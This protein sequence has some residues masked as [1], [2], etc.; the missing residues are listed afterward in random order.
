MLFERLGNA[1]IGSVG[2][3][4]GTLL[5]MFLGGFLC[6]VIN[7]GW[8]S[9]WRYLSGLLLLLGMA[10]VSILWLIV[11]DRPTGFAPLRVDHLPP[12]SPPVTWSPDGRF[13]VFSGRDRAIPLWNVEAGKVERYLE[14]R[15]ERNSR[16]AFSPDG[17]KVLAGST[18]GI[19]RIWNVETGQQ[20]RRFTRGGGRQLAISPDGKLA[21]AGGKVD[22]DT[23]LFMRLPPWPRK[24]APAGTD[25]NAIKIWNTDTGREAG[26]LKGHTELVASVAFSPDGRRV[27]SG[28]FDGTMRL[29]DVASKEEIRCF[30]GHTGWVTCVAF[31]AD[32]RRALAGYYDWSIRLWDLKSGEELRR[33]TGHRATVTSLTVSPD[34]HSFLSGSSDCTMRLWDLDARGHRRV[35]RDDMFPVRSVSFS[36]HGRLAVCFCVGGDQVRL[37]ELKQ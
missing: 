28:S 30:E 1:L 7:L 29:W 27:L 34:G 17:S 24:D 32:G 22:P 37:W 36:A 18:D 33:F 9:R 3:G 12:G 4:V 6:G 35:F 13:A 11:A 10:N 16:F 14:G 8:F 19:V 23:E 26:Y 5:G 20:L 21:L 31:C 25:N 2:I 15:A